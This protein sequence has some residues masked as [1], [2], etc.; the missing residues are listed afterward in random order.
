MARTR[1]R[2]SIHIATPR[3]AWTIAKERGYEEIVGIIEE[4]EQ[5]RQQATDEPPTDAT[6]DEAARAA[7]ASG[8]IAWLCARRAEGT[9]VNPIRWDEGGLLT[10]AVRHNQP[11]VLRLLLD[12]GFDPDERVSSGEGDWVAYS[13]GYPLWYCAAF[14][15]RRWLR[16]SYNMELTQMYMWIRAARPYTA[17]TAISS[18]RWSN[19]LRRH[20]GVVTRTLRRSI[21]QTDWRGRCS[22]TISPGAPWRKSFCASAPVAAIRRLSGWLWSVSNGRKTI[23]GGSGS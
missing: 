1:A 22:R 3:T 6:G 11:E 19:L 13:Q 14:G 2:A 21:V 23:P 5:N 15:K 10:V 12:Y 20:G 7:V 18:G 9:L 16:F 4:E 17:R 8:D